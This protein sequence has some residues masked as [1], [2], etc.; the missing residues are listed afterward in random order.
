VCGDEEDQ[1][2]EI[3][4]GEAPPDLSLEPWPEPDLQN[5]PTEETP[6]VYE[7]NRFDAQRERCEV[8]QIPRPAEIPV[9]VGRRHLKLP[10]DEEWASTLKRIFAGTV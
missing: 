8:V 10:S 4:Q 5:T 7:R 6:E 3:D 9:H 2:Q 1:V